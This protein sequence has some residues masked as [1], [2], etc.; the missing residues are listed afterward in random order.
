MANL[1]YAELADRLPH[2]FPFLLIDKVV[3]LSDT[4]VTGVKHVSLTDPY[5]VGHFPDKPIFPGVL[6]VEASAQTGAIMV[7]EHDTYERGY[8][9]QLNEFKFVDFIL[10]GD[11]VYI[12]C[13]LLN[14]IGRFVKVEALAKVDGRTVGKGVITYNFEK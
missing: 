10:P 8:I 4:E 14:M 3:E 7:T 2:R 11:S 13:K 6:L 1:R 12:H 9:A 5:L